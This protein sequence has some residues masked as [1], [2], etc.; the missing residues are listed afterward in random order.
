[1]F[2]IKTLTD[3]HTYQV[4]KANKMASSR[5]IATRLADDFKDYPNLDIVGM[6]YILRKRYGVSVLVTKLYSARC[7]TKGEFVETHAEEY[8]IL[9]CY[10]KMVLKTNPDSVAKI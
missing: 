5:W 7:M 4:V 8:V 9:R 3:K 6:R 1:M 10:A 2:V